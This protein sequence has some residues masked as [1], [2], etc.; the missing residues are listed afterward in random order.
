MRLSNDDRQALLTRSATAE[1][2]AW[3]SW[4]RSELGKQSRRAAGGWPGTVSEARLRMKRRI[5][6]ELGPEFQATAQEVEQAARS[7]YEIAR[8][9]WNDSREPDYADL[10]AAD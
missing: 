6:V 4:W 5:A 9:D 1:G 3:A 8:R 2:N 10:D 7:A